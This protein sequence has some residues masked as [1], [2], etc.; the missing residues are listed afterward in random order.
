MLRAG[1]LRVRLVFKL[2]CGAGRAALSAALLAAGALVLSALA[3]AAGEPAPKQPV[4]DLAQIAQSQPALMKTAIAHLAPHRKG[5]TDVYAIGVAG[6][7]MDVFLK[8]VDGGL[9]AIGG[10]L[11]IKTRTLRL[12]NHPATVAHVPLAT[13]HNFA[14]AVHA[15]GKVMDR[16]RDVLLLLL[17]S[18]G[19]R[20]GF[21][22]QLPGMTID[23]TPQQL[24]AMLNRE[25]IKN[26][27]VI[28]SA[29]Y[30]GIFVPPLRNDNTI[31]M[32][33]ADANHTSFGCAPE[34][35]WTYFGDAFFHQALEPGTDF[36][37]AFDHARILIQGWELMDRAQPSNPQGSFGPAL[38][39][40]LA[41]FLAPPPAG[42]G[43]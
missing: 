5:E 7:P 26:R 41:P 30:S 6:W 31:V 4:L 2:A 39:A 16:D 21:A 38:V 1:K 15:V 11:P 29:C 35:D 37:N 34:N 40:K 19:D 42:A 3:A 13:P 33:A 24:A 8:E 20:S 12:I 14:A 23:L 17:T 28:V 9:A 27:V 36:Q 43:H 10:V 22:L 18:H 32:T 25:G